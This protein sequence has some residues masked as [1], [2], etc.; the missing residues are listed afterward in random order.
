METHFS[1]VACPIP[2]TEE[3]GGLQPIVSQSQTWLNMHAMFTFILAKGLIEI[4]FWGRWLTTLSSLQI[5]WGMGAQ[6]RGLC[7][8]SSLLFTF[9]LYVKNN[10]C[11][12]E[13]L[14]VSAG[15]PREHVYNFLEKAHHLLTWLGVLWDK[16]GTGWCCCGRGCT[17]WVESLNGG[18]VV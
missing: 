1:I 18:P 14:G 7:T 12:M 8:D 3:P 5:N 15:I 2:L 11:F 9:S 13:M 4:A 6:I 10:Q 17:D 16:M